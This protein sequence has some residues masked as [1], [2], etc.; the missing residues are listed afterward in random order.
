[1]QAYR[2]YIAKL[3]NEPAFKDGG[4]ELVLE[5]ALVVW[6]NRIADEPSVSPCL[7]PLGDWLN[8]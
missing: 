8:N 3:F 7:R 4:R 6:E 5:L 1:L 2:A